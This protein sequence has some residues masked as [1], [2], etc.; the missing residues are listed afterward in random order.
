MD[1]IYLPIPVP[2]IIMSLAV[3]LLL[4][5]RKKHYGYPFR[6]IE[7]TQSQYAIVDPE[8]Y[9]YLNQFKWQATEAKHTFYACRMISYFFLFIHYTRM[10]YT[11]YEY[12]GIR[13][14]TLGIEDP[15]LRG[16]RF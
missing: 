5:F 7:L 13:Y 1:K 3:W 12:S 14:F 16:D 11:A 4:A 10:Q 6:R 8:D 15:R 2:K 9:D